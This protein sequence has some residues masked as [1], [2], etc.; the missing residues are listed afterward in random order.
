MSYPPTHEYKEEKATLFCIKS[1][2]TSHFDFD[3][4]SVSSP[5]GG[6]MEMNS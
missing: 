6:L 1:N 2:P 3:K 4:T 5:F